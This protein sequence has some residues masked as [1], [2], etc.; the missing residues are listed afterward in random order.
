MSKLLLLGGAMSADDGVAPPFSRDDVLK[1][2]IA[3]WYSRFERH[4]IPTKLVKVPPDFV[5]YLLQDGVV[6][7]RAPEGLLRPDDPRFHYKPPADD[8]DSNSDDSGGIDWD[9]VG[10]QGV[11]GGPEEAEPYFPELERELVGAIEAL[12]GQ[13]FP[14]MNWSAPRVS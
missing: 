9:D 12:G 11:D 2:S 6:L 1:C 14:K 5:Q 4:T 8:C 3:H 13:V 10:A 7:P